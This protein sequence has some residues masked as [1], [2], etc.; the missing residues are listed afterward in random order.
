[1]TDLNNVP[2]SEDERWRTRVEKKKDRVRL[3][4]LRSFELWCGFQSETV[5]AAAMNT[6]NAGST[7][8]SQ[9]MKIERV[10]Q[11]FRNC[12]GSQHRSVTGYPWRCTLTRSNRFIRPNQSDGVAALRKIEPLTRIHFQLED[13]PRS[14]S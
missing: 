6:K 13:Q 7:P 4:L 11:F 8:V 1:M 12:A 2:Q 3:G 5:G 14:R 9:Y 10:P